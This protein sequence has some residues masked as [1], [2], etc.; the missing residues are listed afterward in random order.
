MSVEIF[1]SFYPQKI[2][3]ILMAEKKLVWAAVDTFFRLRYKENHELAECLD[4][5]ESSGGDLLR[6]KDFF[7]DCSLCFTT[8]VRSQ[9]TTFLN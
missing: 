3:M 2:R 5:V 4:A 9:V 1:F 7:K 8:F 6:A